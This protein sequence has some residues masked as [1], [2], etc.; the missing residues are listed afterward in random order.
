MPWRPLKPMQNFITQ[1]T[2]SISLIQQNLPILLWYLAVLWVLNIINWAMGSRLFIFGIYPRHLRGL[3][4]IICAP[5]LHK[6]F[7]HLFYNSIPLILLAC[8]VLINGWPMFVEITMIIVILSGIFTWLGGRPGIHIGASGLIMGYWAYLLAF[9][10]WSSSPVGIIV[11]IIA[12]YYFGSLAANL[13][14]TTERVS[15]EGH[16]YG[17]IAGLLAAAWQFGIIHI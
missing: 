3:P 2:F 14:P 11:G 16:I 1:L 17:F 13:L 7:S 6:D 9:A 5:W 15:W 10:Y 12:L 4:G 8:G